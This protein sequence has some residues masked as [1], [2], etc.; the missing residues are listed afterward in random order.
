MKVI[1]PGT[2]GFLITKKGLVFNPDETPRQTYINGDGYITSAVKINGVWTTMGLHRLLALTF[3]G[4]ER[5]SSRNFVNHIDG[6]VSNNDLDNLEWVTS[7]ENNIHAAIMSNK[8]TKNKFIIVSPLGEMSFSRTCDEACRLI[9][10][11]F[12]ELWYSIKNKTLI[13]GWRVEYNNGIIPDE[14]RKPKNPS[15]YEKVAVKLLDLKTKNI[16]NFDS[17]RDAANAFGT[18]ASLVHQTMTRDGKIRMFL[19]RYVV[20]KREDD[21]PIISDDDIERLKMRLSRPVLAICVETGKKEIHATAVSFY[22]SKRFS[23]KSVTTSLRHD[24][25]KETKG[26]VYLYMNKNNSRRLDDYISSKQNKLLHSLSG[27]E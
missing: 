3:K 12:K 18:T 4:K 21:L 5:T 9:D 25:I 17:I 26:Y 22:L 16:T 23:K 11:S 1:I 24:R 14:L 2:D 10:C 7:E 20:V 27:E 6:D 15:L 19:K 8:V 13:D